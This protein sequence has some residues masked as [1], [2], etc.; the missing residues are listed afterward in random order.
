MNKRMVSVGDLVVDVL[1]DA[2]LPLAVDDHQM[3][4]TLRFEPGGACSTVLAARNMGLEA[5]ALGA[6][7]ADF[8]GRMLRQALGAAG[9]DISALAASSD[10]ATTTVLTLTDRRQGGHVFLGHYGKGPPI[11]MTETAR[12]LLSAADAL[13]MPGYALVEDRLQPLLEGVFDFL[14]N[15]RLPL[16]LDVGPFLGQLPPPQLERVLRLTD[17]L[18][19]TEDE[20]P[21]V[22]AGGTGMAAGRQLIGQFP[23]LLMVI[24]MAASGCCMLAQGI[25]MVCSG[26][27]VPLVDA[28]GAGD[29]F[30]A[31]LIWAHLNQFPLKDC[32]RIANAMGAASVQKVGAGRNVPS[33]EEVQAVL[34]SNNTGIKLSC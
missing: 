12:R 9:V 2:R 23:G 30:A 4:P 31:A 13:F 21:L 11:P 33:R 10:S 24:K 7:G 26:Y 3:S 29:S 18:M 28:V 20:I 1:L 8:Q 22:A 19:L 34:D 32:G 15:H 27:T 5:A 6:V 25:E 16:Y 17:V 14:E